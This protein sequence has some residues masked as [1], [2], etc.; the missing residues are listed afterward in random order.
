MPSEVI[1]DTDPGVD[2]AMAILYALNS[3]DLIV[4]AFVTVHGN[5][6]VKS[7]TRNLATLLDVLQQ[8]RSASGIGNDD[9]HR[10][11]VAVGAESPLKVLRHD[12]EFFHGA[13]GLGGIHDSHPHWTCDLPSSS[14]EPHTLY[15]I[16]ER[17]GPEEILHQLRTQPADTITLIGIGPLT[18]F[19]LAIQRDAKTFARARRVICLGGALLVPGNVI[20]TAEFNFWADPHA[21]EIVLQQTSLD[22]PTMSF[23][24]TLLDHCSSKYATIIGQ[25]YAAISRYTYEVMKKLDVT[26]IQLAIDLAKHPEQ[27]LEACGQF[28]WQIKIEDIRMET[29]GHWTRGMCVLDR[30]HGDSHVITAVEG[31]MIAE[32][33]AII[34]T[35]K[36]P[37][38]EDALL[39]HTG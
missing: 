11:V 36:E 27:T 19:A 34:K 9:W 32:A 1:I 12:A 4:R 10:P 2:D 37:T 20:P 5:S 15:D 6:S 3:P 21:A 28:G 25:F 13:D 22:K 29:E 30:R 7:S 8:H 35:A 23:P 14:K 39:I 26:A 24:R 16:S 31:S 18:N 33:E 38:S 17:D